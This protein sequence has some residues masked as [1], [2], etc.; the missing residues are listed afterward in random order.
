VPDVAQAAMKVRGGRMLEAG[1]SAGQ[2]VSRLA[3]TI[4]SGRHNCWIT[5]GPRMIW[6]SR[7][8]AK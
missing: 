5:W 4:G 7:D 3:A 1:A 6:E 8:G 2:D